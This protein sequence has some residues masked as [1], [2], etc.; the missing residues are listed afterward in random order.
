MKWN[1]TWG[2]MGTSENRTCLSSAPMY[3]LKSFD[4]AEGARIGVELAKTAA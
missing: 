3:S 2:L 4:F 1:S